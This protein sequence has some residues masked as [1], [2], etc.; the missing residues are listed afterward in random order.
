MADQGRQ[1][2]QTTDFEL[3]KT[4]KGNRPINANHVVKLIN[5]IE[6]K[7]LLPDNPIK[8]NKNME[9]VDGQHRYQAAKALNLPIY[10]IIMEDGGDLSDVQ[11][12]NRNIKVWSAL[13]YL[14]SYIALGNK[15]YIALKEFADS[16]RLSVPIS[17]RI[18]GGTGGQHRKL[19][20]EFQSGQFY[21]RDTE[22]AESLASL[23]VEVRKNAP[24]N[25]W[26]H[27]NCVRAL[28]IT[29]TKANPQWLVEAIKKY[30]MIVTR[31]ISIKDYLM[32]FEN[33]INTG[34]PANQQ[35]NLIDNEK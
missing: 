32:E 23:I 27:Y 22:H 3:F 30:Q 10:Y 19:L 18:M 16:Y 9:I 11:R 6:E 20:E 17:L 1:I 24:D 35:V 34:R 31:R 8:V 25:C 12:L 13:D 5:D 15:E 29:M 26:A 4:I 7:N 14:N 21:A 33:I 2:L 28:D